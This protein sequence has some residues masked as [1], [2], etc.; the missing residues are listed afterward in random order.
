M[1]C[2]TDLSIRFPGWNKRS[3]QV[4]VDLRRKSVCDLRPRVEVFI[5]KI[6]LI[7]HCPGSTSVIMTF[8]Y[9]IDTWNSGSNL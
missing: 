1:L 4:Q 9:I 7:W 8:S 3:I 2:V 6:K 5:F